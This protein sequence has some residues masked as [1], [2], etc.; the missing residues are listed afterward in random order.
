M[1]ESHP[2]AI[3]SN[4]VKK[5]LIVFYFFVFIFYFILYSLVEIATFNEINI[6]KI[7][8]LWTVPHAQHIVDSFHSGEISLIKNKYFFPM[9]GTSIFLA[10][11]D[12]GLFQNNHYIAYRLTLIF[13]IAL[14]T[15]LACSI[16]HDKYGRKGLLWGSVL[17]LNPL[18]FQI[19]GGLYDQFFFASFFFFA[20]MLL[21]KVETT[22]GNTWFWRIISA[23]SMGVAANL[24]SDMTYVY[25]LYLL[26]RFR[27]SNKI[28]KKQL[29]ISFIIFLFCLTPYSILYHRYSGLFSITYANM[30]HVAYISLGQDPNNPWGIV[31]VDAWD[32][33]KVSQRIEKINPGYKSYSFVADPWANKVYFQMFFEKVASH[34]V[35]YKNLVLKKFKENLFKNKPRAFLSLKEPILKTIISVYEKPYEVTSNIVYLLLI[36][37]NFIS[38]WILFLFGIRFMLLGMRDPL[39]DVGGFFMCITIMLVSMFEY[40]DRHLLSLAAFQGLAI[41]V[42]ALKLRSLKISTLIRYAPRIKMSLRRFERTPLS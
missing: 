8:P 2:P 30:G 12:F 35:Y 5:N 20:S 23:F 38:I 9:W 24:R 7:F 40:T 42:F 22:K 29:C 25:L 1:L 37:L 19:I 27:G 16:L 13:F 39:W 41:I 15:V 32:Y 21:I 17:G 31:H 6:G 28:V 34:P 4:M 10:L 11:T 36:Y 26:F 3:D 18:L 33:D 14:S